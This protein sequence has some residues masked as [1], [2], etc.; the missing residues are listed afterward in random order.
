[1]L[2]CDV[3]V[4]SLIENLEEGKY[5]LQGCKVSSAVIDHFRNSKC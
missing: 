3:I 4:Y 5:L 2:D 1:M